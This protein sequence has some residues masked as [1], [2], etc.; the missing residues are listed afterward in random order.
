MSAGATA[1]SLNGLAVVVPR[2]AARRRSSA[3]RASTVW[4][5]V[6]TTRSL[7]RTP[8][9]IGAPTVW[10]PTLATAGQGMKIAIL[11]DGLDQTH[12]F[13]TPTG[14]TLSRRLPEGE[15]GL[16]DAE[17]D[18]RA[19]HSRRASTKWKYASTPF[20][21]ADSEHATNVAGIAAGDHDT[22]ATLAVHA[23][24]RL[25]A[26]RRPRTSATTRC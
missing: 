9:L 2:I 19:R 1:S 16:H 7:D 24:S 6:P 4:P 3:C 25:R 8:Q 21:P 13:F 5:S 23:R 20:D 12:V 26:S 11:D 22:L 15:H 17:G 18:R 14:F 10:G